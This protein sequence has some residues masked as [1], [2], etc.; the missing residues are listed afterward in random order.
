MNRPAP[1][2][3]VPAC[4]RVLGR[5]PFYV[6]GQKYVDA[7]RLAGCVPLV[8][9]A[10]SQAE[11]TVLLGLADGLLLTGSPSNVHPSHFG[12]DVHDPTLPLDP[13]RDDWTLPII[14]QALQQR[15]PVLG[16]CRGF[17]EVNVALGGSLHQAV[18]EQ[19]GLMDHRGDAGAPVDVEYGLSHPVRLVSG[20]FLAQ[21][22]QGVSTVQDG[23]FM[24]NSL[25][26]QGVKR[27]AHG[28][29]VEATA[30]DGV[31]EAFTW[32]PDDGGPAAFSL[33]MQWHPEWKAAD[34]PVSRRVFETFGE[35]CRAYHARKAESRQAPR[36]EPA[37][38]P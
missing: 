24:V 2:V 21:T 20:G 25:H 1:V 23:Q 38:S 3:L 26:G 33:C 4:H 34:N 10:A 27:L 16:I 5:H 31:V 9:P 11:L 12:E 32:V 19:P 36:P 6:A 14:R 17:Q 18:H 15:L 30:M 28:L 22:L 35:A 13:A 7:I 29:R 8:V 37:V